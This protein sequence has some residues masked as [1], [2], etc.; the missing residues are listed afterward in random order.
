MESSSRKKHKKENP[1]ASV[2]NATTIPLNANNNKCKEKIVAT[3]TKKPPRRDKSD[4]GENFIAPDG[5]WAWIVCIAAGVSNLTIYPCI[6]QFGFIF[7]DRLIKLGLTNSQIT[8]IINTHP[9][10]SACTGL[11]NGPMFRRYTFRQVA[12]V[13]SI[14]IFF[15]IL[16]TAFCETFLEYI[17]T[18]A[19]LFGFGAGIT[20][21]AS[22]LA[23]NTYFKNKRRKASG[24][25][26]TITGLGPIVLPHIVTSLVNVYGV[27]GTLFIFAALSLHTFMAA[28]IFEPVSYHAPKPSEEA[29]ETPSVL[30]EQPQHLC[31]YCEMQ[32]KKE[33]GLFSSQYLY[34]E[35][36]E[37]KPGFEI[38]EPGTPMLSRANDG[39]YGSRL[40]LASKRRLRFRTISSSKDLENTTRITRLISEDEELKQK[41]SF[42]PN[43]F[44]IERDESQKG[45]LNKRYGG[46]P[47]KCTCAEERALMELNRI[48]AYE[49][50]NSTKDKQLEDSNEDLQLTFFEKV[51]AFFDLDLL[52]DFSFVNLVAGLTMINFG[53]LNFSILTPFILNDFGLETS[54][55]TLSI[56]VLGG[57]DVATRFLVPFLTE[58]I[59]WDNRVFFLIGVVGISIGRTVVA[60]TRS[61]PVI[62]STFAVIGVFKGVRTIF[63]PLVIPSCVPLKRLPAA[64]GL[65]LLISGIFTLAGGP[66]VGLVRDRYNYA[67]ALHC[68]NMMTFLAA[69]CWILEALIRRYLQKPS[70]LSDEPR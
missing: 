21:S 50:E 61:F 40:S 54:Q 66:F 59:A 27:Q 68:L 51:V 4:L 26:W 30:V 5:G 70:T 14:L 43:N 48:E 55:I 44:N 17:I 8:T 22:T 49:A 25:S 31:K 6:Q 28:L 45:N 34:Q 52:R 67:I 32:Q 42:K 58:K 11:L 3:K 38:I 56:S 46:S 9:A 15:G 18:Y 47:L 69:A 41:T 12:L 24:F 37:N 20:V 39:L 33:T 64:S 29:V 57:L 19:L 16:L 65:Q 60:C 23:V 63:W 62:I 36:D 53:E 7:R 10:V 2:Y 35:D 1:Y 13:G